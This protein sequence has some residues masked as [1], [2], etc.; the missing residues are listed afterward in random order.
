MQLQQRILLLD[1]TR[2]NIHVLCGSMRVASTWIGLRRCLMG[3]LW[4]HSYPNWKRTSR[5]RRMLEYNCIC[6]CIETRNHHNCR[7][8]SIENV[9]EW[10]QAFATH[11]RTCLLP[12]VR[13]RSR[14][15][16]KDL[17]RSRAIGLSLY[18]Y[19]SIFR[20]SMLIE[21][22]R[23]LPSMGTSNTYKP[24]HLHWPTPIAE[25]HCSNMQY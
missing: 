9:V 25:E 19:L 23:V 3:C 11:S 2:M 13:I 22:S 12:K 17:C 1:P 10:G 24:L 7:L 4:R 5:G 15:E 6:E 16:D 8:C 21:W 18:L 14:H 20:V